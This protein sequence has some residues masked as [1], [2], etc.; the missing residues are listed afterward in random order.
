[1]TIIK[2]RF[3]KCR[4]SFSNPFT[5]VLNVLYLLLSPHKEKKNNISINGQCKGDFQ[6]NKKQ[7]STV[8]INQ[9]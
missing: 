1:M 9:V 8:A 2:E 7:I 4:A 5:A 6:G 3:P